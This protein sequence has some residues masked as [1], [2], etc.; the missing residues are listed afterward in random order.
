MSRATSAVDAYRKMPAVGAKARLDV[1]AGAGAPCPDVEAVGRRERLGIQPLRLLVHPAVDRV[2][3]LARA[4]RIE[5]DDVEALVEVGEQLRA[6]GMQA[7]DR[8]PTR[9]AEV[10][11]QRPDAV[12]LDPGP[13]AA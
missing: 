4:P 8:V 9:T 2:A 10:H 13:G 3:A 12:R 1:A 5:A 6:E 11:E 7:A